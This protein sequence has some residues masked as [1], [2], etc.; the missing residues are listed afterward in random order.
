MLNRTQRGKLP[1]DTTK[2]QWA[3]YNAS[4]SREMLT[5]RHLARE[6][7]KGYAFAPVYEGRRKKG[8]F[9]GAWHIALDFDTQDTHSAIDTMKR[10]EFAWMFA[11]FAY[12]TP[13]HTP[14]KP[15]ARLVFIFPYD[16]PVTDINEYETL[17]RALLWRFPHADK[18]TKD[19]LRLFYGSPKA[20]FW[21]NWSIF[22]KAARDVAIE[23]Y[24]ASIPKPV[25]PLAIIKTSG[26]Y[27]KY[28]ETAVSS[29]CEKVTTAPKGQRHKAL[30]TAGLAL[31]SLTKS[32]WAG[33][34][35]ET[36]LNAIVNAATWAEGDKGEN[37]ARRVASDAM[38]KAQARPE[39]V[40]NV[41]NVF[42][43]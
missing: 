38:S 4:F 37:E 11:S 8:C 40:L 30:L 34:T 42:A 26:D 20:D 14:E 43:Y 36:A 12:T 21:L 16:E 28:I 10:D 9:V 5:A 1:K 23:Q 24:Q 27:Q 7:Y 25:A 35:D 2:P 18:A 41:P 31:G 22:P 33:L 29:E 19:A 32:T 39:P 13:S 3:R 6:I 17:Y 15:K